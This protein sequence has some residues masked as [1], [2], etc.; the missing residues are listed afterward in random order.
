MGGS[1]GFAGRIMTAMATAEITS[2]R[3]L[4]L[5]GIALKEITMAIN[6]V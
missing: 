3:I 1:C 4:T 2:N 5:A 6:N